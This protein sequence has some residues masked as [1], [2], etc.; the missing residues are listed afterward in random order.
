MFKKKEP[1][2]KSRLQKGRVESL[3]EEDMLESILRR[4]MW[5]L[6]SLKNSKKRLIEKDLYER[7]RDFFSNKVTFKN[8][9]SMAISAGRIKMYP[10]T[11]QQGNSRSYAI[12]ERGT[13]D[14]NGYY[15][16]RRK[17][18]RSKKS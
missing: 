16:R 5:I 14:L 18:V 15:D 9:L 3:S 11:K 12:T 13:K 8:N 10:S 1:S 7:V 2:L 4:Q 17:K 6:K